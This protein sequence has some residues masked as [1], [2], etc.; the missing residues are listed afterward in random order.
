ML[1]HPVAVHFSMIW[2]PFTPFE[3]S[4]AHLLDQLSAGI[5]HWVLEVN[6]TG[7]GDTIIDNLRHTEFGLQHDIPA[8]MHAVGTEVRPGKISR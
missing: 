5:L 8:C 1:S 4:D 6:C 7:N 2:M 3:Q